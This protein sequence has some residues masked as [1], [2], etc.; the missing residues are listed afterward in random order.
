MSTSM[1]RLVFARGGPGHVQPID[2]GLP[3]PMRSPDGLCEIVI[4]SDQAVNSSWGN[5]WFA[6]Q[7]VSQ[8]CVRNGKSGIVDVQAWV[9]IPTI[10]PHELAVANLKLGIWDEKNPVG[11]GALMAA[12]GGKVN[13]TAE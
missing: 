12:D 7:L 8:G 1:Q 9:R 5:V 13:A 6:A 10:P 3:F 4:D 11:G 2:V